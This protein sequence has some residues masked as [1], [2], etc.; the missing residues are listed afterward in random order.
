VQRAKLLLEGNS[1]REAE[2]SFEVSLNAALGLFGSP[3]LE[4][5]IEGGDT[6]VVQQAGQVLVEGEV[7]RRGAYALGDNMTLVGALAAAGGI[8][9]GAKFD[10]VEVVR[11]MRGERV[12]L[13]F[14]LDQVR[15]GNQENLLLK[16][17][18]VVRV[19]SAGGRRFSQDL[20]SSVQGFIRIGGQVPVQ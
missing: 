4:V 9:Y 1:K 6:I 20:F 15:T 17:G 3:P 8:T 7:E 2:N 10:E 13:L 19:P 16:N 14:D 18:D 5:P 12:S 11:K